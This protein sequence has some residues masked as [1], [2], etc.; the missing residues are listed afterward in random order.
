VS[1]SY[2]QIDCSSAQQVNATS[3]AIA[4]NGELFDCTVGRMT[5]QAVSALDD[6]M[7]AHLPIQLLLAGSSLLLDLESLESRDPHT[8]RIVG[9]VIGEPTGTVRLQ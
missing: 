3:L 7:Y 9:R 1:A 6:A 5:K 4:A 2:L 8:I